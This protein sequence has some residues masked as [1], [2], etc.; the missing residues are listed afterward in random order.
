MGGTDA[1]FPND[2]KIK[3]NQNLVLEII[4]RSLQ[5]T[6]VKKVAVLLIFC[7]TV[8]AAL[9]SVVSG[10]SKKRVSKVNVPFNSVSDSNKLRVL[11]RNLDP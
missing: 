2:N 7:K 4:R 1:I 8:Q 9:V 11:S 6:T 10:H 5:F 3:T